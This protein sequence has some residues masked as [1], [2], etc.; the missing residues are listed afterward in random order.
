MFEIIVL[1]SSVSFLLSRCQPFHHVYIDDLVVNQV[2]LIKVIWASQARTKL[3]NA[4][5][6]ETVTMRKD[7]GTV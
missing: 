7:K 4:R 6:R 3:L 1:V 5:R 2:Q